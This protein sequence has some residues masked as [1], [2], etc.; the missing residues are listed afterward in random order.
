MEGVNT[1]YKMDKVLKMFYMFYG[2]PSQPLARID[3]FKMPVVN[4]NLKR[5][6]KDLLKLRFAD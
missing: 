3:K 4:L 6:Y 5:S 2:L 1:D